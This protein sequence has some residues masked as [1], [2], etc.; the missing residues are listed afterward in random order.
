MSP[1]SPLHRA[2]SSKVRRGRG[3][4]SAAPFNRSSFDR[5]RHEERRARPSLSLAL[6]EKLGSW[7][8]GKRSPTNSAVDAESA[9]SSSTN[10]QE[11]PAD[12]EVLEEVDQLQLLLLSRD[13]PEVVEHQR[14]RHQEDE[15]RARSSGA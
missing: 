14:H 5:F 3:P 11:S 15:E 9:R 1:F 4:H 7:A 6:Q 13:R 12:G 8:I 10:N 2:Q